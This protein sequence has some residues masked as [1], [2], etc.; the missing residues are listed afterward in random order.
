VGAPHG[1]GL[2][3][4][5]DLPTLTLV[6]RRAY[7]LLVGNALAIGAC[8]V[9]ASVV[10]DK[11]LSDPEGSFL[12]P[13]YIRLPLLLFGA[14]LLDLLPRIAWEAKFI[15]GRIPGVVRNRLRTHW[16]RER[17]TLVSLGIIC[18][19]VV[20]VSYRN[21]KSFLPFVLPDPS[22][23]PGKFKALSYDHE[24]NLIDRALF[25]GHQPAAVVQGLL[26]ENIAAHLLS[27]IY[28]WFLPLV[29]LAVTAWLVWSRNMSFGYWF[30]TSQC[31][32]WTLGTISYYALPTL[33]PGIAYPQYYT[34]VPTPATA[35]MD[36]LVNGRQQVL[37]GG[38]DGAVQSIA[39]FA[40][41]H[42]AITLLVALMVQYTLQSRWLKIVF[43][44]NFAITVVA[45]I[46][47][48]WHYVADD[49]AGVMIALVSFYLGGLAS[50]QKFERKGF[51]SH[52]TTTTSAIPV[53]AA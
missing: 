51:A 39:G 44:V 25:F 17:M 6:Y 28:L 38:I 32:A 3:C 50:G 24:L 37:Y 2:A 42:T 27:Y 40:S 10:L 33:G 34:E 15:P 9:V 19:Y 11:R 12:G 46:Y 31:I 20:Y 1:L 29:P 23:P 14:L 26:G 18:F 36:S 45:T 43:W 41:L 5:V 4:D 35:L 30:V 8:A 52:P 48:G 16:D 47:F 53:D 13:S 7:A 21:L 22:A 49:V